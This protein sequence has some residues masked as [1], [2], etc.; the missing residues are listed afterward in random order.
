MAAI[1]TA[2][3]LNHVS[4]ITGYEVKGSLAGIKAGNLPQ[5]IGIIA[6]SNTANQT[7][8]PSSLEF[9]S[10]KEV[11][12]LFGYGSPAHMIARI[13]RPLSGDKLGGIP[14]IIYPV[15]E[16]AGATASVITIGIT[17]TATKNATHNLVIAGRD[18]IDGDSYSFAVEIG[19]AAA[20]I[21]QKMADAVNNILSS[22]VIGSVV[23]DDA[24]FTTKWLGVTA[25]DLTVTIETNDNAAGITY[26]EDANVDGAGAPSISTALAAIGD[27]W[28]TI[29]VNAIGSDST[30][31]DALEAWNGNVNDQ[32][33]RF[34]PTVFKPAVCLVGSLLT[35]LAGLT[36]ITDA[37]K[38]EMTNVICPAP[39]SPAFSFEAAANVA[40]IYAPIAQ[41]TPHSDP[42][43]ENYPDMPIGTT[44][45]DFADT[46]K[47]DALIKVGCSTIKEVG[48][49]YQIVDL[50][51]TYHPDN[52]PQ[53]ATIFRYVRD[54][55]GIDWNVKYKYALIEQIYV[56]G[57]TLVEDGKVVKAPNTISPKRWT[58][59]LSSQLA[60]QLEL[61]AL[62]ADADYM[63]ESI[64]VQIGE[65]NANR[66][67]TAFKI[68][69]T[70]IARV[71]PTTVE[72]LFNFGG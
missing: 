26:S 18:Q 59:I 65:L 42:Y 4:A 69:R 66:F 47:R 41:D 72:T 45:G 23:T 32:T 8:L 71:Q 56:T 6:E 30:T 61:D 58:S 5:R 40:F 9:T 15:L 67:E 29:I 12:D 37:R 21:S 48:G 49:K 1:S 2:I 70:G 36:A 33:G 54:L 52:E 16:A 24:V 10:A 46:S 19:D 38:L 51:T 35:T 3:G 14:T 20:E 39:G 22:P 11:G 60:P 63:K 50:V 7:G 43:L 44:I 31:L 25:A 68:K 55:V 34:V 27:S 28:D 62:S 13:L 17:G 64:Q 57:K 53:T